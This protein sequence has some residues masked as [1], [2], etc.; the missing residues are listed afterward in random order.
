MIVMDIINI[1][2]L[3]SAY[4]A[5]MTVTL[6]VAELASRSKTKKAEK[7]IE[8]YSDYLNIVQQ[9]DY[10]IGSAGSL[11]KKGSGLTNVERKSYAK[12]HMASKDLVSLVYKVEKESIKSFGSKSKNKEDVKNIIE[13]SGFI[14]N[15]I[16]STNTF[17]QA[18]LDDDNI[19]EESIRLN[20]QV[21]FDSYQEKVDLLGV[22]SVYLSS[23]LKETKESSNLYLFFLAIVELIFLALCII[24]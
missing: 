6:A 2:E 3:L 12:T 22:A 20:Y 19:S 9:L 18:I 10:I 13:I 4:A 24:L 7:A 14:A 23:K 11:V 1:A 5:L 21:L 15:I 8:I 17:Y 16:T